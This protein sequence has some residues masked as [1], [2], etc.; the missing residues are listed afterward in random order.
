MSVGSETAMNN[1]TV[2]QMT[3]IIGIICCVCCSTSSRGGDA[4]F[5]I[6]LGVCATTFAIALQAENNIGIIAVR[7]LSSILALN[8]KIISPL[9]DSPLGGEGSV[10]TTC[11]SLDDDI[12][13]IANSI[14][15]K[16]ELLS[17]ISDSND[18]FYRYLGIN[19]SNN[20]LS[21]HIN[22]NISNNILCLRVQY[23][24]FK[25][26]IKEQLIKLNEETQTF[27]DYH[28]GKYTSTNR[29]IDNM[30]ISK[31]TFYT[32]KGPKNIEYSLKRVTEEGNKFGFLQE[33][34]EVYPNPTQTGFK[35]VKFY[36]NSSIYTDK[37][38][39]IKEDLNETL[40][41]SPMALRPHNKLVPKLPVPRRNSMPNIRKD[42]RQTPPH[43]YCLPP[44][45]DQNIV[46]QDMPHPT[47]PHMPHP[48]PP[49]MPHPT[50]PNMPHP[51]P[52]NIPHPI[53]PY[54]M[55]PQQHHRTPTPP[56]NLPAPTPI[57][58]TPPQ[59]YDSTPPLQPR[60]T[61]PHHR[62]TPV[63]PPLPTPPQQHR[64]TPP[65][66]ARPTPQYHRSTP[67]L[68]PLPTPSQQYRSTPPLQA[69]PTPQHEY[70]STPVLHRHPTPQALPPQQYYHHP[71][72]QHFYQHPTPPPHHPAQQPNVLM[73]PSQGPLMLHPMHSSSSPSLHQ[74]RMDPPIYINQT[75]PQ[76]H[77]IIYDSNR[78]V[79][80]Q[81]LRPVPSQLERRRA[82]Y[83]SAPA[84]Q[85]ARSCPSLPS[86]R[87]FHESLHSNSGGGLFLQHPS[88]RVSSS[89]GG[90]LRALVVDGIRACED[91]NR[92]VDAV[93][94][95]NDDSWRQTE[96]A[97]DIECWIRRDSPNIIFGSTEF[98]MNKSSNDI[99]DI[100]MDPHKRGNLDPSNL[101]CHFLTHLPNIPV[102][103]S[104][105]HGVNGLAISYEA[106]QTNWAISS[107]EYLVTTVCQILNPRH[108]IVARFSCDSE[109]C[110][111]RDNPNE[112]LCIAESS[113]VA[114]SLRSMATRAAGAFG[115][116]A[117][118]IYLG[119][120]DVRWGELGRANNVV[121]VSEVRQIDMRGRAL[122]AMCDGLQLSQLID[123]LENMR[124]LT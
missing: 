67:V 107:R 96:S 85:P 2:S 14:G 34:I 93:L 70:R 121:R 3:L 27:D 84:M 118:D 103:T 10:N 82:S 30:L 73:H 108:I 9:E 91:I 124:Q 31:Q 105:L 119:G 32:K 117:G 76:Q 38:K 29:I 86:A 97:E 104:N 22:K 33:V 57:L 116:I 26:L 58:P 64:S 20:I 122:S 5:T 71:T 45:L 74:Q 63:L 110:W 7:R 100:L 55:Q 50:P 23:F 69:R 12:D 53:Q 16:W 60:P 72:P 65:L 99:L 48:T 52:P 13:K 113:T 56:Q 80:T 41:V 114:Q 36:R 88:Q 115:V 28:Y 18:T 111:S 1:L 92:H 17:D 46:P 47:P 39:E 8:D 89:V 95:R 25:K 66:Q 61:P 101:V 49:P 44:L 68:P 35:I 24:I 112:N 37:R 59:Q 94:S 106:Y 87:S 120:W 43:D 21:L 98:C 62:S 77:R 4:L 19:V 109:S 40:S 102:S 6:A 15:G 90:L 78:V 79:H 54:P 83:S 123:T 75:P 42:I 81:N 51:T 11:S